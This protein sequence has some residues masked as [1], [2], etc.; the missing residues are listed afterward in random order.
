MKSADGRC[1]LAI[2]ALLQWWGSMIATESLNWVSCQTGGSK[3]ATTELS[4]L[5]AGVLPNPS[6]TVVGDRGTKSSVGAVHLSSAVTF[7]PVTMPKRKAESAIWMACQEKKGIDKSGPRRLQG[8]RH[9]H[10][11]SSWQSGSRRRCHADL[12]DADH[13]SCR[14]PCASHSVYVYQRHPADS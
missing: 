1:T 3:D 10:I 6:P 4:I 14:T 2:A 11:F 12:D 7:G 9:V 5:A 8:H 13:V